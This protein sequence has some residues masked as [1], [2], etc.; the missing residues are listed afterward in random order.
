MAKEFN[1]N[2][3]ECE[4]QIDVLVRPESDLICLYSVLDD[5]EINFQPNEARELANILNHLADFI[6]ERE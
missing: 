2:I 5:I 3:I 4:N 6:D 1:I